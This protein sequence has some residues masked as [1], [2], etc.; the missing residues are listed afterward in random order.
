MSPTLR[1]PTGDCSCNVSLHRCRHAWSVP[2]MLK[3][4]WCRHR[5]S[6]RPS[7]DIE[8]NDK[9]LEYISMGRLSSRLVVVRACCAG[10][11]APAPALQPLETDER[12]MVGIKTLP[13]S[14]TSGPSTLP[15]RPDPAPAEAPPSPPLP[16]SSPSPTAYSLLEGWR[17]AP[18]P[19][20]SK[21][22]TGRDGGGVPGRYPGDKRRRKKRSERCVTQTE[23][24]GKP[25][26]API[27]SIYPYQEWVYF[28]ST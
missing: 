5:Q 17:D 18:Q 11:A 3:S 7:P 24:G 13:L 20:L 15:P 6:W 22:K 14:Y 21:I 25:S 26:R 4:L 16:R 1:N 9:T 12:R 28:C 10:A 8:R 2:W 27:Q 19:M 23:T